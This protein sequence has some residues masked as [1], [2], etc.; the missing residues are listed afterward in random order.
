MKKLMI[1]VAVSALALQLSAQNAASFLTVGTDAEAS[2]LAATA[3]GRAA[4]A[5]AIDNNLAAAA[6][7]ESKLDA[8]AG[9]SIWNPASV[10]TGIVSASAFF[11]VGDK[12][13]IAVGG[14]NFTYPSYS[15]TN[16]EGRVSD[17]FKPAEM[18]VSAGASF[19]F[20]DCLSVGLNAKFIS[21][22]L[23]S[24]GSA[25]TV[26]ADLSLAY[27]SGGLSAGLAVCNI[28]GKLNYGGASSYSLPMTV[29]AGAAYSIKGLTASAEADYV[30]NG[31]FMAGLGAEYWIVDIVAVRAG[32]HYGDEQK[33][34]PT[35]ASAGLGLKLFGVRLNASYLLASKIVGGSMQFGLGYSF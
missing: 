6:L 27:A 35:Y 25:S 1:T 33:A 11:K 5:Y 22:K 29:K 4:D 34:I 21:S 19:A 18:S 8:A 26:G 15:V 14:R 31:G 24:A 16:A 32:F 30:I 9:Y 3:V 20:T 23:A 10:K 7:S 13:A 12:L 28:G 17:S 2:A